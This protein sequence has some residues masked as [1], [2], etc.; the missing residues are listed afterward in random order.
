MSKDK[1]ILIDL[2][3]RQFREEGFEP[4]E[5]NLEVVRYNWLKQRKGTPDGDVIES[6]TWAEFA[7]WVCVAKPNP[8]GEH[9]DM[10]RGLQRKSKW[11]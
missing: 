3:A 2:I 4:C 8:Y 11:W 6:I 7:P 10:G 5:Q 1:D 9:D